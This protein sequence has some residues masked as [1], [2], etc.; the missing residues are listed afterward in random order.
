V[1]CPPPVGQEDYFKNT[2]KSLEGLDSLLKAEDLR[3]AVDFGTRSSLTDMVSLF[4]QNHE[5]WLSSN[6]DLAR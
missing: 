2:L 1:K 3:S 6:N 5:I 4:L